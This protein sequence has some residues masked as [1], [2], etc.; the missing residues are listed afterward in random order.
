MKQD[1][2]TT[3]KYGSDVESEDDD[4]DVPLS[5]DEMRKEKESLIKIYEEIFLYLQK[6]ETIAKALK[7]SKTLLKINFID[8]QIAYFNLALILT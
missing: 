1:G 8:M 3:K 6:G 7:V 2:D 5:G 4:V